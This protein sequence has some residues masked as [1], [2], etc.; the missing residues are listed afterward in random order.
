M[1][2]LRASSR[3]NLVDRSRHSSAKP[4]RLILLQTLCRSSKSQLLCNQAN[5]NSSDKTPGVGVPLRALLSCTDA[6]K[7]P[8]VSPLFATLT[9][10]LSRKSFPCHSYANTRDRG[11]H[12]SQIFLGLGS[13][14]A[15]TKR[16]DAARGALRLLGD[17]SRR[18]LSV[19]ESRG[20]RST[21]LR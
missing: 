15:N 4:R 21:P 17:E 11:D 10:S 8:F 16:P 5:P 13:C 20:I 1:V 19:R 7:R 3:T 12:A 6:Q 14:F 2:W 9:H 18:Q